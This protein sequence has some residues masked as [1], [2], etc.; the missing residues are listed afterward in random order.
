V[1]APRSSPPRAGRWWAV[2]ALAAAVLTGCAQVSGTAKTVQ[3]L[4]R[5]GVE[6]PGL[7][8]GTTNGVT[9]VKVDY[10]SQQ[11][12]EGAYRAELE[13]VQRIVWTELPFRFDVLDVQ[14]AAPRLQDGQAGTSVRATRAQLQ[15][16]FGPRPAR[17]D[18]SAGRS[19]LL[20][21]AV[22]GLVLLLLAAAVILV[23]VLVVRRG[24]ANRPSPGAA[25]WGQ[26]PPGQGR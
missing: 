12:D 23:I 16:A 6:R 19:V 9:S 24:R 17:L 10:Q 4:N 26:P 11:A 21:L 8:V 25:G 3:A 22:V 14:A 20:V 15:A 5:L 2:L 7:N 13:R 18:Q 1:L